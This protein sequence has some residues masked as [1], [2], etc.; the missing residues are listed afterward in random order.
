M[1]K[2]IGIDFGPASLSTSRYSKSLVSLNSWQKLDRHGVRIFKGNRHVT[3]VDLR[4]VSETIAENSRK[5]FENTLRSLFFE[6]R[7]VYYQ[8]S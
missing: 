2:S 5:L 4:F 1:A 7:A 3:V 8:L 6:F